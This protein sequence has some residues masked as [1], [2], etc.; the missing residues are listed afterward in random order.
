VNRIEVTADGITVTLVTEPLVSMYG[1]EMRPG[2]ISVCPLPWDEISYV[3]LS[4]T[5]FEP[6]G[7]RLVLLTVD[8]ICGE[9]LQVHEDD[10][11]FVDAVHDLCRLSEL[12]VPDTAALTMAGQTIWPGSERA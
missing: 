11:G 2:A 7:Q 3:W 10:E 5:D 6:D 4:A 1:K 8:H 9:F 12:P